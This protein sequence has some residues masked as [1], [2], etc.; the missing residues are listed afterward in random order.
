MN[1]AEEIK[2]TT[3]RTAYKG[4][5][6][7]IVQNEEGTAAWLYHEDYGIKMLMFGEDGTSWQDFT[8]IVEANLPI[9]VG[10]YKD[11]YMDK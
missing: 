4:F 2:T 11:L 10:V 8:E 9:E 7:D 3:Y 5:L 1:P 6:V